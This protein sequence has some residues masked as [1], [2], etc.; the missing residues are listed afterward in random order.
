M[1]LRSYLLSGEESY[2]RAS[3]IGAAQVPIELERLRNLTADDL[4][5]QRNIERFKPLVETKLAD[6]RRTLDLSRRKG[7]DAALNA[8]EIDRSQRLI[9]LIRDASRALMEEEERAL[10]ARSRIETRTSRQVE[11]IKRSP[12]SNS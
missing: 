2:L 10:L 12:R 1:D 11:V 5:Q 3:E 8:I 4:Q 9:E 6:L 7:A